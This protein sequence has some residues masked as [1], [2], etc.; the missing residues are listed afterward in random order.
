[1]RSLFLICLL[2]ILSIPTTAQTVLLDID[3]SDSVLSRFGPNRTHFVHF[4][5]GY[6]LVFGKNNA[7]AKTR[8]PGSNDFKIGLRYKYKVS[9]TVALGIDANYG[10]HVFD[11]RQE[12]GKVFADTVLHDEEELIM[13]YVEPA[14]YLRFNLG[15]R[16]NSMGRFVDVGAGIPITVGAAHYT[17]NELPSGE[18]RQITTSRLPYVESYFLQAFA[19]IGFNNLAFYYQYRFTGIF[20][21]AVNYPGLPAMTFGLQLGI[22]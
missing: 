1:M 3:R 2:G 9:E 6:G 4:Y 12:E 7:G 17:R 22:H 15:E 20:K 8:V 11:F 5:F 14:I 13:T 16:G 19:R 21:E 18:I 10:T